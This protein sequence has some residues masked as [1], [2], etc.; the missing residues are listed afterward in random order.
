MLH[1]CL[2]FT[3]KF[4][5]TNILSLKRC[6]RSYPISVSVLEQIMKIT[7]NIK[8]VSCNST[9]ISVHTIRMFSEGLDNWLIDGIQ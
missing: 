7:G 1:P 9:A 8:K 2:K 5:K 6:L 4:S 3:V